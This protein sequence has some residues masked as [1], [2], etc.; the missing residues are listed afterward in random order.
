M[1]NA[2]KIDHCALCHYRLKDFE[3]GLLC[4][5]TYTQTPFEQFCPNFKFREDIYWWNKEKISEIESKDIKVGYIWY[6]SIGQL[7]AGSIILS[8]VIFYTSYGVFIALSIL[9]YMLG[10]ALIGFGISTLYH[11]FKSR[12]RT[13]IR[14]EN[15]LKLIQH[16][17][18][19]DRSVQL[20][21]SDLYTYKI[22]PAESKSN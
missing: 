3:H 18:T 11:G 2:P 21:V 17:M 15:Y 9:I 14:Y 7:L 5:K 22:N 8:I 12:K 10:I 1:S 20:E 6:N 16:Y 4:K 19:K 13:K